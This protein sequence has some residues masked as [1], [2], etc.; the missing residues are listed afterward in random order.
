M[1]IEQLKFPVGPFVMPTQINANDLAGWIE[2]I[3][4]FSS[5]LKALVHGLSEMQLNWRYRPGGWTILQVVHH[6]ADSHMNAY[7]RFKLT[8]TEERPTIKPYEQDEWIKFTDSND[9]NLHASFQ[10]LEGLHHRW[11][12]TLQQ[13]K[14]DEWKRRFM[15]PEHGE[16]FSLEETAANYAWHCNHHLGH[17]KQALAG[18]GQYN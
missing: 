9:T 5:R 16:T 13:I 18:N 3:E 2:H 14:P 8:L 7:I 11:A 4:L 17:V 1:D 12:S 6:C 15:H 10:I